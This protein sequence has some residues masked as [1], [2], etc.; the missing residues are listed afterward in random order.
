MFGSLISFVGALFSP[1]MAMAP[2]S[3]M[4]LYDNYRD[5]TVHARFWKARTG[6]T[7]RI[8]LLTGYHLL[9]IL[10]TLFLT[11]GGTYGAIVDLIAASKQAQNKPWTCADNSNSVKQ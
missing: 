5:P 4:W 3:L 8:K 1:T 10:V 9:V 11:V 6:R 7:L 2:Y